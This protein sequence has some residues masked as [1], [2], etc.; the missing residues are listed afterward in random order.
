MKLSEFCAQFNLSPDVKTVGVDEY[1]I[2]FLICRG[3]IVYV[4]KSS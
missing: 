4:G 3:Q 2:Y 1:L